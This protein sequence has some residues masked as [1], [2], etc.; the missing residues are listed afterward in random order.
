MTQRY[1]SA[2][3]VAAQL[4]IA[5]STAYKELVKKIKGIEELWQQRR[6]RK[7]GL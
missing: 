5:K 7:T 4:Q 2:K 3:E 1:M 6:K